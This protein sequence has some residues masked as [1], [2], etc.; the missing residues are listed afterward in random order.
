MV[1]PT[2]P[3]RFRFKVLLIAALHL[4]RVGGTC[5]KV[6]TVTS[7]SHLHRNQHRRSRARATTLIRSYG[8]ITRNGM[9]FSINFHNIGGDP[10]APES[11]EWGRNMEQLASEADRK[12][13]LRVV[14]TH[15]VQKNIVETELA[16]C[17]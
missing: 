17:L 3:T 12:D 15:R 9:R 11:N 1:N 6:P 8:L 14:Q 4:P 13:G 7:R 5:S 10:L 16:A 2:M